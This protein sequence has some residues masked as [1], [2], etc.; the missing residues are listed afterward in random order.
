MGSA[1]RSTQRTAEWS[2]STNAPARWRRA[3][4]QQLDG[5]LRAAVR[6]RRHVLADGAGDAELFAQLARQALLGRLAGLDLAAGELPQPGVGLA[7]RPPR[8]QIGAV[9]LDHGRHHTQRR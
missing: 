6:A 2:V 8:V 1:A 5:A 3:K 9:T 4:G 7:R